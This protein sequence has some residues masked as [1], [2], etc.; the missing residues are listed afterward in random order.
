MTGTETWSLEI[1]TDRVAWLACDT[2][3]TSTNVLSAPVLRDL[4]AQL[5]EIAALRPVGVVIRSA[6]AGGF[7]AGADIKEFLAIRTPAEGYELVR[8]GQAVLQTLAD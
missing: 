1:D 4:A 8:A 6:K 7:I 3:G 5:A 2:P